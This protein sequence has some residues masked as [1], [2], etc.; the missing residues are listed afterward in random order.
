MKNR[1]FIIDDEPRSCEVVSGFL[2]VLKNNSG[3]V[4]TGIHGVIEPAGTVKKE[5]S[6][7]DIRR[8]HVH[9]RDRCDAQ[10]PDGVVPHLNC[11]QAA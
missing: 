6:R 7:H 4:K 10:F 3:L 11:G 5:R 8:H 9:H 2:Q 1:L